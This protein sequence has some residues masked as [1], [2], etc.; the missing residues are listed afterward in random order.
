MNFKQYMI[1]CPAMLIPTK[2]FE[3]VLLLEQPEG[4][5]KDP[6]NAHHWTTSYVWKKIIP[7]IAN[8]Y[9][10]SINP[11][12]FELIEFKN[13]WGDLSYHKS[14][15]SKNFIYHDL[16][17]N[18]TLNGNDEILRVSQT[19]NAISDYHRLYRGAHKVTYIEN[20]SIKTNRV[21]LINGDSMT[22]PIIPILANYFNKIICLDNRSKNDIKYENLVNWD[23]ITD[24]MC[25]FCT[26]AWFPPK[27]FPQK[28]IHP[29]TD[30]II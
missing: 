1:P 9:N 24:Y 22:I 14:K 27:C 20:L 23:E 8:D 2:T 30:G 17:N 19:E 6:A 13:D 4:Y 16:E 29:Y 5:I 26:D 28:Y 15:I 3:D 25:M 7:M 10:L 18:I 12:D 11:D 21:L